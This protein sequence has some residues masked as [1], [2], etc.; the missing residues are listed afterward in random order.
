MV[1]VRRFTFNNLENGVEF[2]LRARRFM[3]HPQ[4][5]IIPVGLVDMSVGYGTRLYYPSFQ[6]DDFPDRLPLV[7]NTWYQT[8]VDRRLIIYFPY[9]T[10]TYQYEGFWCLIWTDDPD[11]DIDLRDRSYVFNY[12]YDTLTPILPGVTLTLEVPVYTYTTTTLIGEDPGRINFH[13]PIDSLSCWHNLLT[14]AGIT[15]TVIADHDANFT[16]TIDTFIGGTSVLPFVACYRTQGMPGGAMTVD[17]Y[18]VRAPF[19]LGR[20]TILN[21]RAVPVN[22]TTLSSY[23]VPV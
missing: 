16:E 1:H 6:I 14:T 11:D 13:R 22:L 15:T 4:N 17:R 12:R 9:S 20:I 23:G 10:P 5:G 21:D 18:P 3:F 2:P 7:F 19:R 8:R